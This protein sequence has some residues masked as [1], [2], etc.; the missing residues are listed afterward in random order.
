MKFKD[1]FRELFNIIRC[2]DGYAS[3]ILLLYCNFNFIRW[4]CLNYDFFDKDK[5]NFSL[6]KRSFLAYYVIKNFKF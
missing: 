1:Q 2:S 3:A 4:F 6:I 5:T